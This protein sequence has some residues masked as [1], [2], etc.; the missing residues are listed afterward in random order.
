LSRDSIVGQAGNLA[1][2]TGEL[3]VMTR[4]QL[5]GLLEGLIVEI[6]FLGFFNSIDQVIEII[7]DR[8]RRRARALCMWLLASR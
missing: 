2:F 6:A 8:F 1:A 3:R 5:A 7:L 4:D